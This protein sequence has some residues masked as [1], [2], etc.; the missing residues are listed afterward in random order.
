MD[1]LFF[2]LE[3][4]LYQ[5]SDNLK[6]RKKIECIVA[7]V[8]KLECRFRLNGYSLLCYIRAGVIVEY[9]SKYLHRVKF[10]CAWCMG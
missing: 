10:D 3:I 1:I 5:Q 7:T 4:E 8:K 2:I 6:N 9:W